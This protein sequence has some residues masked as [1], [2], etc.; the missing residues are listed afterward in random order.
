MSDRSSC[1]VVLV[2][3]A[4]A[5]CAARPV[6]AETSRQIAQPRSAERRGD[7]SLGCELPILEEAAAQKIADIL[8]KKPMAPT[9]WPGRCDY[10]TLVKSL[11]CPEQ[12]RCGTVSWE[13]V[14]IRAC[15]EKQW[16]PITIAYALTGYQRRPEIV[17]TCERFG[18][19]LAE[20][21]AGDDD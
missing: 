6:P 11:R 8:R 2:L 7:R 18:I 13:L 9:E 1:A 17:S 21:W 14:G 20:T 12:S 16:E 5:G 15:E 3:F 4:G 19:K 10:D